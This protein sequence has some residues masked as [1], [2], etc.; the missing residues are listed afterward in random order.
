MVA[1]YPH[2]IAAWMDGTEKLSDG[3]YR[4]YHVVCELIYLNDGPI[5]VHERGF[6]GRCNQHILTF[7]KNLQKLIAAGKLVLADGKITNR[8]VEREL[9]NIKARKGG[10][11]PAAASHP[12]A[13]NG[14][15]PPSTPPQVDSRLVRGSHSKPLKTHDPTLFGS[16]IKEIED[17]KGPK[18]PL[19]GS[20]Q[21][22]DLYRRGKQVL[23]SNSGGLIRRLLDAK[24]RNIADARAAIEQASNKLDPREYIGAIANGASRRGT[25]NAYARMAA[26]IAM[27]GQTEERTHESVNEHEPRLISGP[28]RH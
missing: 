22:A 1:Y 14:T 26:A 24:G 25:G 16:P 21:E 9:V 5:V 27:E 28:A 8:R 17:T 6:A 3:E 2:N 10:R 7:R 12:K 18:G 13:A 4:A 11:K 20:D 23:G 19:A 15:K